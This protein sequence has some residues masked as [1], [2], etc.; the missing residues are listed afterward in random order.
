MTP[1]FMN[2]TCKTVNVIVPK[3]GKEK[4]IKANSIK[5][6]ADIVK[7]LKDRYGESVYIKS[8]IRNE[9]KYVLFK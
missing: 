5:T 8:V 6:T 7:E 2:R 4:S 9:V 1:L 3:K